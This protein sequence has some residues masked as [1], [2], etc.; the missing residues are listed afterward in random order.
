MKIR[1][2]FRAFVFGLAFGFFYLLQ[3]SVPTENASSQ[4][5]NSHKILQKSGSLYGSEKRAKALLPVSLFKGFDETIFEGTPGEIVPAPTD[6]NREL[7]G[8]IRDISG[9]KREER[10]LL[11]H[12]QNPGEKAEPRGLP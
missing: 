11:V 9:Q 7:R 12:A 10:R 6:S 2:L 4:K 8:K 1:S 5:G 3:V